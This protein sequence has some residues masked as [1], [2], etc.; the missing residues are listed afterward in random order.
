MSSSTIWSEQE[1]KTRFGR[2]VNE[3]RLETLRNK[4]IRYLTKAIPLVINKNQKKANRL[5][6]RLDY[7]KRS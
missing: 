5:Q 2:V 4:R 1:R 6:S 3:E 7:T